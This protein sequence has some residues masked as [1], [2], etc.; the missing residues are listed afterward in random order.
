MVV[1]I[2]SGKTNTAIE[3]NNNDF[4]SGNVE[5][6]I[7]MTLAYSFIDAKFFLLGSV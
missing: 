2:N 7:V 3:I 6:M 4:I 1:V 5:K